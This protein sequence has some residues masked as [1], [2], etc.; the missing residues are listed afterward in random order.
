MIKTVGPLAMMVTI[1]AGILPVEAQHAGH[2]G[3]HA[4]LVLTPQEPGNGAFAAIAEIVQLLARDDA[5]DWSTVDI[6]ALRTHLVDMDALI[7]GAE[8]ETQELPDGLVMSV[9]RGGRPG[10]AAE[11]MVPAHAPVLAA[12]TGWSS[13]IDRQ[14]ET[15]VWTVRATDEADV[16]R[17]KALGFFGLMATGDHHREHHLA[18]AQGRSTH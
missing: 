13:S 16:I 6:D 17:L 12:E 5:T 15:I 11:R 3:H 10:A 4:P 1:L 14:S 7:I 8:V 18:I 9:S 2:A